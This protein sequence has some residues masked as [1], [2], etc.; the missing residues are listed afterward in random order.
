MGCAQEVSAISG[1]GERFRQKNIKKSLE[2]GGFTPCSTA[3]NVYSRPGGATTQTARGEGGRHR[4][5]GWHVRLEAE[6]PAQ[7][8][9]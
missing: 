5:E 6:Q 8:E 7:Q 4:A 2:R 3:E 1:T 9:H